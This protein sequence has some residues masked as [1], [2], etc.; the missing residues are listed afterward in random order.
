MHFQQFIIFPSFSVFYTE[1]TG[2]LPLLPVMLTQ[3]SDS[4]SMIHKHIDVEFGPVICRITRYNSEF[5]W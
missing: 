5:G 2:K 1:M 3:P 4:Q